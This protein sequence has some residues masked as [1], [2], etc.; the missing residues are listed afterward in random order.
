[1]DDLPSRRKAICLRALEIIA[2]QPIISPAGTDSL[3]QRRTQPDWAGAK[4]WR[5]AAVIEL[6]YYGEKATLGRAL[7]R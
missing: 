4:A 5:L 7:N 2:I 6:C 3:W 1:M